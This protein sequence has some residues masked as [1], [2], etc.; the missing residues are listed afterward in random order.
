M[1][2][3]YPAAAEPPPRSFYK[4]I[5][6]S[7]I[8]DCKLR[9][10]E[11]F[12]KAYEDELSSY[13]TLV[14]PNGRVF[15]AKLEKSEEMLWF[16]KGWKDFADHLSIRCGF[17]IVFEY[18]GNSKFKVHVFDLTATEIQYP[19]YSLHTCE[20]P[21]NGS[22]SMI[23]LKRGRKPGRAGR[24][25]HRSTA[26]QSPISSQDINFKECALQG[27]KRKRCF[28]SLLPE[29]F[30]F[31]PEFAT[32]I[33]KYG[34]CILKS[35]SDSLRT[36]CQNKRQK[37]EV[38]DEMR[39]KQSELEDLGKKTN[40]KNVNTRKGPPKGMVVSNSPMESGN[41]LIPE[42]KENFLEN[43]G[44]SNESE[45]Q[46]PTQ[47][48]ER[49]DQL[50]SGDL[51]DTQ[52]ITPTNKD[53]SQVKVKREEVEELIGV[54]DT[55]ISIICEKE[56]AVSAAL[57]LKLRNPYFMNILKQHNVDLKFILNV[58]G[59]F[60][61]KYLSSDTQFLKLEG[62]DGKQWEVSCFT[63]GEVQYLNRGWATFVKEYNLAQGDVCIFELIQLD[64]VELKVHIFRAQPTSP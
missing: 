24:P 15:R 6:P 37:M 27:E 9:I 50:F 23:L 26:K 38:L 49:K 7:I 25:P 5:L 36:N 47:S 35:F 2:S 41:E 22:K 8:S 52:L 13:A 32:R 62:P 58:P 61:N 12:A 57:M 33:N 60:G 63:N 16:N 31:A 46:D 29:L 30:Q 51:E 43:S 17:F 55:T 64:E 21:K 10:P 48:A 4:I 44:F 39:N 3:N 40:L 53:E 11:D 42:Y 19:K 18:E 20:E 14:V 34:K 56:K 1:G 59:Y 45:L 54:N 28:H